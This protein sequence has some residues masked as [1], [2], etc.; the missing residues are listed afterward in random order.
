MGTVDNYVTESQRLSILITDISKRLRIV[1]FMDGLRKPLRGSIKGFNPCTLNEA[2]KKVRDMAASS[3]KTQA[4]TP[5]PSPQEDKD[6][7]PIQKKPQPDEDSLQELRRKKLCFTCKEPWGLGHR[8]LEKGKIQYI[9][10]M[11]DDD[12]E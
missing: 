2:I 10:M 4:V 8:C 3:F 1:L 7:E 12:K 6:K 9:E 11:L 5:T